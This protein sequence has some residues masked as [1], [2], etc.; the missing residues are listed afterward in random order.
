[1]A[2]MYMYMYIRAYLAK[3][4]LEVVYNKFL[5][6]VNVGAKAAK[7]NTHSYLHSEVYR[8]IIITLLHAIFFN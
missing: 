4:I 7:V 1:M 8:D 2:Y 5:Y 3:L 6:E